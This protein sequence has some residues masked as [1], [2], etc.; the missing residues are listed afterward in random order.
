MYHSISLDTLSLVQKAYP[1]DIPKQTILRLIAIISYPKTSLI[2][3][4]MKDSRAKSKRTYSPSD[5]GVPVA[6][7]EKS[8]LL[9]GDVRYT[10]L[11]MQ[12][13]PCPLCPPLEPSYDANIHERPPT[14]SE[15]LGQTKYT[16]ES[17]QYTKKIRAK[18]T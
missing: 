8:A 16:D 6:T 4:V 11:Y 5:H 15:I 14:K 18:F 9:T 12:P 13:L 2:N 7:F 10:E 17:K 1:T 3:V